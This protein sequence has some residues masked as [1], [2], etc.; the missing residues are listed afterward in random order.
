[1]RMRGM[2][3]L[4]VLIGLCGTAHAAPARYVAFNATAGTTF[5]GLYLAPAGTTHWGRNQA[6]NDHDHTL[7]SGERLRLD[8][9]TPGRYDVRVTWKGHDC[10][11]PGIDLTSETSFEI[12]DSDLAACR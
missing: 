1:M 12:R 10:V 5:D 9:L 2:A 8:A 11:K 3:G 6:L 7:E 4:A